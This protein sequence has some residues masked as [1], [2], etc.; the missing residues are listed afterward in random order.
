MRQEFRCATPEE[1][2]GSHRVFTA[3]L[4]SERTGETVTIDWGG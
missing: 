2:E 3:A 1:A 4:E